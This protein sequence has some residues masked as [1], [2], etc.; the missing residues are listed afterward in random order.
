MTDR[1]SPV[2]A[3]SAYLIAMVGLFTLNAGV[4][5]LRM[6]GV[7]SD[8]VL[9]SVASVFFQFALFAGGTLMYYQK[10]TSLR[11]AMRLQRLDPLSGIL[12]ALSALV[13]VFVLTG[14]SIFWNLLLQ[15][16]GLV[17]ET[18]EAAI[19][20]TARQLG[21]MLLSS[22]IAPAVCEEILMRGM[23]L[24]AMEPLG[25]RR[26]VLLSGMMFA[27]LHGRIEA[28]PAHLL[29]GILLAWMALR[30]GSLFSSVL[31][32]AVY[33]AA[34]LTISFLSVQ[35]ALPGRTPNALPSLQE[36]LQTLPTM[37]AMVAVWL[38]LLRSA[39]V[40]GARKQKNAL[41][42]AERHALS[43]T[44]KM[45]LA[46]SVVLLALM[47]VFAVLDMLPGGVG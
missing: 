5:F 44:A 42:E 24:P 35:Y 10:N 32:H 15:S 34:I 41:P 29:L 45:L 47:Q 36:A 18:G 6:Q 20:A 9:L 46:L 30:T 40:R 27:L 14:L 31:F 38:L 19:P 39:L 22:A 26:A 16:M 3:L 2:S 21:W 13:G 4:S 23:L 28:L 8:L 25:R 7:S 12:I 37:A 1:P 11:P 33:N 43:S 17:I